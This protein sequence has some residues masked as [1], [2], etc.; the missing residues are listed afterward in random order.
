MK[1]RW[2]AKECARSRSKQYLEDEIEKAQGVMKGEIAV[3]GAWIRSSFEAGFLDADAPLNSMLDTA[4]A[5]IDML[6]EQLKVEREARLQAERR[7]AAATQLPV[8]VNF[9]SR[10]GPDIRVRLDQI[11]A[12]TS[13]KI[14]L[15]TDDVPFADMLDP[16]EVIDAITLKITK[17]MH[18]ATAPARIIVPEKKGKA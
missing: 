14:Y 11:S 10:R 12:V 9:P 18:E 8:F 15:V 13:D 4:D 17:T 6:K 2:D 5:Q 3:L 1:V 7:A 16:C